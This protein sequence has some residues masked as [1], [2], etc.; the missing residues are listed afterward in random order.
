[1]NITKRQINALKKKNIES[2]EQLHRWFPIRYINN[3]QVT[4]VSPQMNNQHVT[5]IGKLLTV[6]SKNSAR[7]NGYIELIVVDKSTNISVKVLSFNTFAGYYYN[8]W[9]GGDIIVSG[10]LSYN[11]MFRNYTIMS[12]EIL[13]D[14]IEENLRIIPILSKVKGISDEKFKILMDNS[15]NE[16]EIDTIS[17]DLLSKYGIPNINT[18]IREI[19]MP[20]SLNNLY[21]AQCRMLFDDMF[22]LASQF[23]LRERKQV[24]TGKKINTSEMTDNILSNLPFKLTNGQNNTYQELKKIMMEGKPV[25]ALV[26]GDVGCGKTITAFL[27]M[28]LMAENG[29]RAAMMAPTK[30]LAEQHFKKI[31]D[32]I[33]DTDLKAVLIT[34]KTNSKTFKEIN[35]GKYDILI[36]THSII[37]AK[38][39]VNIDMMVIDEEH[40]FG[41]EQR[42]LITK[43]CENVNVISMSATPIPR[44]LAL[45]LF[46]NAV[47]V[48]SIKDM[49]NG[50]KSIITSYSDGTDLLS[51]IRD[52]IARKEQV[53][54]VCPMIEESENE[55][56]SEI[57]STTEAYE[58]YKQALPEINIAELN[59]KTDADETE[60]ILKEFHDGK[61]EMLIS[62]TVVEVGVD[63]PNSTLMIIQNAERFGLAG[64]HQLR[65]RV[66]RGDKQSYCIL[67]AKEKNERIETL[68]NTSDGFEISSKD[69][70]SLRKHGTLFGTKQSGHNKY[71]EER[72]MFSTLYDMIKEDVS[73][74]PPEMLIKHIE[75]I[76][77]AEVQGH[78]PIIIPGQLE[79][80]DTDK[81]DLP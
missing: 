34:G 23:E 50:R 76:E 72:L 51:E 68:I 9:I 27:S 14:N 5:I 10:Q 39:T 29:Y 40:K 8:K 13:S 65:G 56:F 75:K 61:I 44:T 17:T 53:Y 24:L 80:S 35:N 73:K 28:L 42:T 59:G 43:K 30:I 77:K 71:I 45:A 16:Q 63:V 64:M 12:P 78:M 52:T 38:I 22:Y 69:M 21:A 18:A 58:L 62:T 79:K 31:Q 57:L 66:G 7:G 55:M 32:L 81:K 36:G 74:Y 49:P 47:Q 3:S 1:M 25:H 41:V 11:N 37:S 33:K 2:V 70:S 46:G 20:S 54:M 15:L 4:P 48:F 6:V 26:Q 67:V 60:R 19:F